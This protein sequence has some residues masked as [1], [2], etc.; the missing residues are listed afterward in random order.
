LDTV[1]S[2]KS[3][4]PKIA[5]VLKSCT[6]V[7]PAS[8]ALKGSNES[9]LKKHQSSPSHAISTL[10]VRNILDASSKSQNEKDLIKIL[11]L[12]GADLQDASD[13]FKVLKEWKSSDEVIQKFKESAGNQWPEATAF[14]EA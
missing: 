2:Y 10:R 12:P 7:I 11:S 9:F 6:D 4:D 3:P 13:A 14:V 5:S 8:S 1:D